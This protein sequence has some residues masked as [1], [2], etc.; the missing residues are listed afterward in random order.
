MTI[1]DAIKQSGDPTEQLKYWQEFLEEKCGP[2]DDL[3]PLVHKNAE[4]VSKILEQLSREL[5]ATP[6]PFI[7]ETLLLETWS[8]W[9][10]IQFTKKQRVY[11][12]S[13]AAHLTRHYVYLGDRGSATR[14]ALL[15][16]AD[17]MLGKH[18]SGGGAGRHWLLTN[19]GMT[20]DVLNEFNGIAVRN[21]EAIEANRQNDWSVPFGFAEDVVT[22]FALEKPE[23]AHF[24]T[25]GSSLQ[26]YP[27]SSGYFDSLREKVN[28]EYSQ[29]QAHYKGKALEDLASYL[30]LLIP[31]WVP[32]RNL[33]EE[34]QAFETDILVRNLNPS[35]NLT[36]ELLGRY[37]LVECKNWKDSVG[38]SDVGYFLYRMRLTHA[39]FGVIFAQEGITGDEQ[40]GN[41]AYSLIRKAFHEDG[42]TCVVV[43]NYDLEKLS[44]GRTTLWSMLLEKI[45]GMQFGNPR[46]K[47]QD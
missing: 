33:L 35:A 28:A 22:R 16:Q 20:A 12:A 1:I 47:K 4:N 19:L 45:E 10:K 26:S 37:F 25:L 18:P 14:W 23:F 36:A 3:D 29:G 44:Q 13:I 21:I 46:V 42:S 43:T 9:G 40:N 27:L 11:R 8:N 30:F 6:F 41:A 39:K 31:G 32:R 38:V 2:D 34:T 5:L 15:T 24:L 17:D 7:A